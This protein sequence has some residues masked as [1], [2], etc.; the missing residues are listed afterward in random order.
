MTRRAALVAAALT[1]LASLVSCGSDS[2]AELRFADGTAVE[3]SGA[4]RTALERRLAAELD[5][6]TEE[7]AALL[8]DDSVVIET[9]L[10]PDAQ[11]A[12]DA[13]VLT[14][15]DTGGRF[16]PAV[17]VSDT[18]TGAVVGLSA[19]AESSGLDVLTTQRPSGST[20]K[21][22]VLLA[23]ARLGITPETKID[24]GLDCLFMTE[25]GPYDAS[26]AAILYDGTLTD[27]TAAS[28]NCAFA[29]IA[30]LAGPELM[31]QVVAD[32]GMEPK[33]EL[34]ARFAVGGNTVSGD[35]LVRALAAVL[36][37]GTVRPLFLVDRIVRQGTEVDL[38]PLAPGPPTVTE[39]ERAQMLTSLA[40]VLERGTASASPLSGG[41]PAAGKT[42][43]QP[44]NTDAWFVGGT[45][46]LT[47][48]VWLGNPVDPADSM[49]ALPE[50]G[51]DPV[52]GARVAE[53][54]RTIL[55]E[56]LAGTPIEP[57]PSA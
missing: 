35:E 10:R 34:G 40:A 54:W 8:D 57:L 39:P 13:A 49:S 43:T 15:P 6:R 28:I 2:G 36:S 33:A 25:D 48:V 42:G 53:V 44:N 50:F 11:A 12:I 26:T 5:A 27:M 18:R 23:A 14:V 9:T 3:L 29:R 19:T 17:L 16:R 52:R 21:L 24:G 22:V 7:G 31:A 30:T 38:A 55:D 32:L 41:R 4:R 46:S 47:A 20:L 45:P 56:L 1:A 51:L 37:D